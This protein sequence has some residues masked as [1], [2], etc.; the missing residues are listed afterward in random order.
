MC[1]KYIHKES[2]YKELAPV[3]ME[4]GGES[5]SYRPR[6]VDSVVRI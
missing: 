3:S 6:R 5:A 1:K 2:H 4:M